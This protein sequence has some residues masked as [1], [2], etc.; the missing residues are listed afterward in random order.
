MEE[1]DNKHDDA[2]AQAEK[3]VENTTK[4]QKT[5]KKSRGKLFALIGVVVAIILLVPVLIAGWFGFIPGLSNILGAKDPVDLGVTWTEADY[6]S[7][8]D[9]TNASFLDYENAP[10]NPE[11]PIKKT[12]FAD[13]TTVANQTFTQEELTAA[14]NSIDWAWMPISNAQVRLSDNTVE[15]SGNLELDNI[16]KFVSFIGGVG[17][18]DN[19]VQTAADWGRRLANGAPIYLKANASVS[20]DVLDFSLQDVKVGRFSI[21]QDIANRVVYTGSSNSI[22][23]AKNFDAESVTFEDGALQFSGT[24]PQ[25]IYVLSE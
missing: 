1:L 6:Q 8:L 2:N 4:T 23:N 5:K 10:P 11:D 22:N 25:T 19:S 14:I 17:Y 15:I 7:Y 21:P 24:Y 18:D 20:N 13:P 12:I 9:K 16:E 3:P